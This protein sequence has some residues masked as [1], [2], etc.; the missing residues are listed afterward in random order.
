MSC[1]PCKEDDDA[2]LTI[3]GGIKIPCSSKMEYFSYEGEWADQ[4]LTHK[5]ADEGIL[6]FSYFTCLTWP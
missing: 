3:E 6:R 4:G 5:I 2:I 1:T